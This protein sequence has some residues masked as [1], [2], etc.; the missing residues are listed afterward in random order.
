MNK[1]ENL[2]L[3]CMIVLVLVLS[4]LSYLAEVVTT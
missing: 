2:F 1:F 3:K 4:A